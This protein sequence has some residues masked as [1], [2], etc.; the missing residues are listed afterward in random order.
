MTNNVI[1]QGSMTKI[2]CN[3]YAEFYPQNIACSFQV[4]ELFANYHFN[5]SYILFIPLYT[6][7]HVNVNLGIF[8]SH[9]GI[10]KFVRIGWITFNDQQIW[11]CSYNLAPQIRWHNI[12][13]G[14][15]FWRKYPFRWC[16]WSLQN[17]N[18]IILFREQTGRGTCLGWLGAKTATHVSI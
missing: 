16:C 5:W 2:P 17:N 11:K 12:T 8:Y 7:V 18:S 1:W 9:I 13:S 6:T 10:N 4:F 15:I 14:D 3:K